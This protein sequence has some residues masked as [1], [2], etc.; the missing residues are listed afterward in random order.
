[1]STPIEDRLRAHFAD[2]AER[3][4]LGPTALPFERPR[5]VERP[6]PRRRRLVMA[7]ALV[8]VA[9]TIT[10]VAAVV[11]DD[12]QRIDTITPDVDPTTSA[13]VPA[14]T[15]PPT[16]TSGAPTTTSP[17][18]MVRSVI[19]GVTGVLGWWDGAR[20]IRQDE[21]TVPAVGGERY[22]VVGV[23]R[24]ITEAVGSAPT[25]SCDVLD[26]PN[27]DIALDPAAFAMNAAGPFPSPSRGSPTRNPARST[28]CPWTISP[29]PTRC[30]PRSRSRASPSRF[31]P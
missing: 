23:D 29:T 16:A 5:H 12:S 8:L 10:G 19:V 31:R 3:D 4:P 17:T 6:D 20:W 25:T 9:G 14:T 18:P 28:R 30:G 13:P 22:Q 26:V 21:G 15:A 24:P 1:M 7:A 27:A 11:R 2:R